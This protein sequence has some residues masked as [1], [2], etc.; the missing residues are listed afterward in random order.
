MGKKPVSIDVFAE[1]PNA[2]LKEA[3]FLAKNNEINDFSSEKETGLEGF[4]PPA[5]GLE[6]RKL[7]EDFSNKGEITDENSSVESARIKDLRQN[8]KNFQHEINKSDKNNPTF[9]MRALHLAI[10]YI[11]YCRMFGQRKCLFFI[12]DP[13]DDTLEYKYYS[14]IGNNICLSFNMSKTMLVKKSKNLTAEEF[15]KRQYTRAK[16]MFENMETVDFVNRFLD[17]FDGEK[18]PYYPLDYFYD[19]YYGYDWEQNRDTT[20][21]FGK[22][23]IEHQSLKDKKLREEKALNSIREEQVSL[24]LEG[25]ALEIREE[26]PEWDDLTIQR[27]AGSIQEERIKIQAKNKL[28]LDDKIRR[29]EREVRENKSRE[30]SI[31]DIFNDHKKG[32]LKESKRNEGTTYGYIQNF[33]KRFKYIYTPDDYRE[34]DAMHPEMP[35]TKHSREALRTFISYLESIG[36]TELNY[37]PFSRWKAAMN[38]KDYK[39]GVK[40]KA[41]AHTIQDMK[42]WLDAEFISPWFKPIVYCLLVSGAR[43]EH[44]AR[45]LLETDVEVR[46]NCITVINQENINDR[47]VR[48]L[49][50]RTVIDT[51]FLCIDADMFAEKPKTEFFWYFPMSCYETL[52]NFRLHEFGRSKAKGLAQALNTDVEIYNNIMKQTGQKDKEIHPGHYRD[53]FSQTVVEW[54]IS[55][56]DASLL[57]G[58][59]PD[60]KVLIKNYHDLQKRLTPAYAK[61]VSKFVEE[62]GECPPFITASERTICRDGYARKKELEE[63]SAKLSEEFGREI[64]IQTRHQRTSS[65]RSLTPEEEKKEKLRKQTEKARQARQMKREMNKYTGGVQ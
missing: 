45:F 11:V 52:L 5:F 32:Y 58:K 59:I 15:F 54:G 28:E 8:W 44:F 10:D 19:D 6:E 38:S 1:N 50:L 61:V 48:G 37:I 62:L 3:L 36:E 24:S 21:P 65:P 51:E 63:L 34:F 43:P 39:K 53:W 9:C 26:H 57:T 33:E 41:S 17:E 64:T 25:I 31:C 46:K 14:Y 2:H 56:D 13:I 23:R 60:N 7:I 18:G 22:T 49:D 12:N 27:R 35:L 20:I 29:I 4:E 30:R 40:G 47:K 16:N 42:E 55:D